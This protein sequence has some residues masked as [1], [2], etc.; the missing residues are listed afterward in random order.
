MIAFRR[1]PAWYANARV[2][3]V[4]AK[5]LS[6]FLLAVPLVAHG[7]IYTW[8]DDQGNTVISDVR[9]DPKKVTHVRV[10]TT[11]DTKAAATAR[12]PA[13]V[14]TPMEEALLDRVRTLELQLQGRQFAPP[15]PPY[16][17]SDYSAPPSPSDYYGYN[18]YY[19]GYYSGFG[20]GY[21]YVTNYSYVPR[22][23]FAFANHRPPGGFSHGGSFHGGSFH[24]GG[25]GGGRR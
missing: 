18:D 10:V 23:G 9:P 5:S 4:V 3:R 25:R 16:D 21:P 24:G 7:D 8:T 6:V 2:T 17:S 19:P 12:A 11:T 14:M 22:P 15:P 1:V 20:Y 13:Q